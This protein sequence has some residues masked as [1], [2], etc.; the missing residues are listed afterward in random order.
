MSSD[1][2]QFSSDK[3]L[4]HVD[5]IHG[6]L[7]GENPPPITVEL[8]MTNACNHR[9]P[10]C[11][12]WS[13]ASSKQCTLSLELAKNIIR[14]L[15]D[16]GVRGLIFTGGGEPLCSPHAKE[17]LE[18]AVGLGLDIGFITNG[19]LIEPDIA[20]T[21]L[22]S[23]RWVRIS[24]DA[25]TPSTFKRTHGLEEKYF[26]EV[27]EGIR[28][29]TSLKKSLKSTTTVG[30]GYL[31]ASYTTDE[32]P[33]ASTLCKSLG[34][35]YLQ[36]RP[37]LTY[38]DGSPKYDDIGEINSKLAPCLADST[39]SYQVLYSKHK[40]DMMKEKNMGRYYKRC[41]GQQFATVVAADGCMYICCHMRGAKK[42]CIG[43][44]KKNSFTDI[45]NSDQRKKVIEGIDFKDCIP[46]CRDN[47]FN[48]VL[49]NIKQPC[50]H[51][52]FL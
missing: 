7:E 5:R 38:S 16:V 33:Q 52:S 4:K 47:T 25:A 46:L 17:A 8:D 49:W 28:L 37:M 50:E 19:A 9:C 3:I 48:Q 43:D 26:N 11:T 24:L 27:L 22:R 42:Y 45:W 30:V 39:E 23:C 12:G 29:L 21:L 44:L 35:D 18:L 14:Q 20:A 2:R 51:T 36:Y 32:M 40:Y 34:V 1:V 15:S 13:D 41:Y 10:E 6:W 31:T